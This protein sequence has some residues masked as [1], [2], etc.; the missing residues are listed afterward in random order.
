MTFPRIPNSSGAEDEAAAV[1]SALTVDDDVDLRPP[2]TIERAHGGYSWRTYV[3]SD[4][5]GTRVVVRVAPDGGTMEPYDPRHEQRILA[6][7]P[8]RP[9]VPRVLAVRDRA[10][11]LPRG[12]GV[13]S[14]LPGHSVHLSEVTDPQDRHRYR[15]AFARALG[16]IHREGDPAALGQAPTIRDALVEE[17]ERAAN[18]HVAVL[19]VAHPA[20]VVG[21]RW[22]Y[23]HLPAVQ[24]PP[25]LCHGD[26]RLH[27]LLWR[28]PGDLSGILDWERAWSGDPMVDV[29]FG[30]RF[31]G[32]CAVDASLEQDYLDAGGHPI[33]LTRV[34]FGERFERVRSYT[35]SWRGWGALRAGRSRDLPLFAIGEA[36]ERAVWG[37]RHWLGEGG[38][39]VPLPIEVPIGSPPTLDEAW[40]GE[41]AERAVAEGDQRL[42]AHLRR[43]PT[44]DARARDRSLEQL[45][46]VAS[47][48]DAP[49][50]LRRSVSHRDPEQ[51]WSAAFACIAEASI[52]AGP[53]LGPALGALAVRMTE[54]PT[55]REVSADDR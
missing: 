20:Y 35:S 12:F 43:L 7:I 51:A 9:E 16:W 37:L 18:Q 47:L 14:W 27:N 30:R 34:A 13:H 2:V 28:A 19:G 44:A 11:G 17:I 40:L 46:S 22:L 4:S 45:R 49:G 23:T 41:L 24:G 29:A 25:V 48:A 1:R 8:P 42:A 55:L 53:E 38:P 52:A 21:L 3:A 6:G 5:D 10:P 36:G 33:D 15:A 32:W 50:E 31:S 26:F 39:L 54:R